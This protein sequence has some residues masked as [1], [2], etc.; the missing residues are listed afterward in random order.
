M[1]TCRTATQ[2]TVGLVLAAGL[3]AVPLSGRAQSVQ[4]EFN[5]DAND[6]VRTI[7]VQTDGKILLGGDFHTLGGHAR[8]HI[9][10]INGDGSLDT[11]FNPGAANI[12]R[13][14][15]VQPDGKILV[16]GNFSSV[17]GM[18]C[19]GIGRLNSDGS[20][21]AGFL[22]PDGADDVVR[23]IT[24]QPDGKILVG[25]HFQNLGGQPRAYIGRLNP[26]GTVDDAFNPGAD[27]H[28]KTIVLQPDGKILVG[29]FF[30]NLA[31]T[32][33]N[34]ITRLNTDG[35]LD[36]TFNTGGGADGAVRAVTVQPDGKI[37]VGGDFINFGGQV[38]NRIV[39][40]NSDGSLDTA[41]DPT[42]GASDLVYSIALQPDGK[43]LV[44]G[45][46]TTL[47]QARKRIARLNVDGSLDTLFNPPTGANDS[48]YVMEVQ[49]DGK[50]L[51][52]GEFHW[53]AGIAMNHVGRLYPADG[54]PD[55]SFEPL[56][57]ADDHV[58]AFGVQADGGILAGGRFTKIDTWDR[59]YF[60]RLNPSR[61]AIDT[62]FTCGANDHV[63]TMAMQAD[64][65][66][67]V[68]GVFTRLAG[69][70]AVRLGRGDSSGNLDTSFAP[71]VNDCVFAIAVQ[72]DS[73]IVVGGSFRAVG[74]QVR[75][76]VARLTPAGALDTGFNPDANDTV[77]SLALQDD[78]KII[79]AG[80]FTTVGNVVRRRIA[81]LN[82][83]GSVDTTF[84]P[85][86]GANDKVYDVSVLS[87]GKVLAVGDFHGL[88]GQVCNHIGRLNTNGTLD[89]AFN[90]NAD[91]VVHTAVL[92][93]DGKIIIGG[94]FLHIG[95]LACKRLARL[96]AD[97]SVDITCRL[98]DGPS[99]GVYCLALQT[100]GKLLL[101][102]EFQALDQQVRHNLARISNPDA[103][104]QTLSVNGIAGA[105]SWI[106]GGSSPEV[107]Q[108]TFQQS[109]DGAA[110]TPLGVGT[111]LTNGWQL[112]GVS[113]PVNQN[114]YIRAQG[115]TRGGY[116][117][118]LVESVLRTFITAGVYQAAADYDGDRL[119]DPGV[120]DEAT[121][122]WRVKL[123]SA[124]YLLVEVP[125]LLGG[126]GWRPAAADFDGDRLAD[127]AVC[128]TATGNWRVMLSSANYFLVEVPALLGGP[129]WVPVAGDVDGD[130]LADP[131]AYQEATGAW[132]F[133]L[134][135]SGYAVITPA[136][137]VGGAGFTPAL[138][139]Y[140][141]DGFA[142]FGACQAITGNWQVRLSSLG[143]GLLELNNLVGRPDYAAAPADYDGDRLADPGA[144][145]AFTGNW[146]ILLSTGNYFLVELPGFLK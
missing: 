93:A 41:F 79:V 36:E 51:A 50:I 2:T 119:G 33:C 133:A 107:G 128:Q 14:I 131:G 65:K 110:W 139:D 17:G 140:D 5:P 44:G 47:V 49:P 83:D 27:Y 102:G 68:G 18:A 113:L 117:G 97:G 12:V 108:V 25:G 135:G 59:N 91:Y 100:D 4:D 52:G 116:S 96:N 75:N 118:A 143:Y 80:D 82:P 10:R 146:K 35:S 105:V 38:R 88:G 126:F 32:V 16:G 8:A 57:G 6:A 101:G 94:D 87:D 98:S 23:T 20:W 53:L 121:G 26:D 29:G 24:L 92:Q 7:T 109:L 70:P 19:Q 67:L 55:D 85:G 13:I 56:Y 132:R 90:P 64:G 124:N 106:R 39:R 1:S 127:P 3:L 45:D 30:T 76:G 95:V 77:Y 99:A 114:V 84:D 62:S 142:D 103:A 9:G 144:F 43:I 61:G 37:L 40:L 130:G 81:R 74:G 78:G 120:Y 15:T 54:K 46:F 34:H 73:N 28:V 11:A 111:R 137:I 112:T 115:F 63:Y 60:A 122:N 21:D 72:S 145:Q 71:N 123:S 89:T 104:L 58:W 69:L 125:A 48:V 31:G 66:F 136:V 22:L 134:S 141:G 42:G 129:G 138:G 86:N